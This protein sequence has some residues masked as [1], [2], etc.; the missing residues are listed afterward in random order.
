MDAARVDPRDICWES[1][2]A[3]Y[4]AYFWSPDGSSC[5]EYELT[6]VVDVRE[7]IA[8]AGQVQEGRSVELFAL[9]QRA[10]EWG[11]VRLAGSRPDTR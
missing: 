2:A 11:L 10:A 3:T 8:W 1:D 9:Q 4:R 5:D 7:V 6:N